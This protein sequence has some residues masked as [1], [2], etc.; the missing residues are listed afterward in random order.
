MVS[1]T[2]SWNK[3][4]FIV[5]IDPAAGVM[6]F[7]DTLQKLTGVPAARAK[8][9]PKTKGLWKGVLKNDF[10]LT[11]CK[12]LEGATCMLMGSAEFVVEPTVKTVFLEDLPPDE[13]AKTGMTAPAGFMNLGNT[14]YMNSTLQCI[15][16][17]P[18]LREGL[19]AYTQEGGGSSDVDGMFTNQL[20][21]TFEQVD[22][23]VD[24]IPPAGFV[25]A[26]RAAYPQFAQRGKSGGFS[27]QDAEE[28]FTSLFASVA[29]SLRSPGT[30]DA[31]FGQSGVAE[32]PEIRDSG[33]KGGVKIDNV[34]DA[35][36]GLKMEETLSC[37]EA[38]EAEPVVV[39]YDDTRKIV[40]NIQGG[41]GAAV[42]INHVAEGIKLGLEGE[43]EKNSDVLGR[44]ALWKK[45]SRIDRLP[46][47]F[48]CQ[49]MRFFWKAT[50]E[51]ADHQGVKCK[52]MRPVTFNE[53]IDMFEFCSARLQAI[54]KV[55]RDKAIAEEDARI[56]AR[57]KEQEAASNEEKK[58]GGADEPPPP[59][60]K[61]DA[62]EEDDD[63]E[64]AS[65]LAAALE[66]S[67][68]ESAPSAGLGLPAD[69]QGKY[70]LYGVVTHKGRD[71]DGG[72]YI[73]FVRMKGENWMCFDDDDVTPCKTTDILA[74]K[75]GG[76]HDMAYLTFYR[77]LE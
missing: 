62:M 37:P 41:H 38:G 45:T 21:R 32:L 29:K 1:V 65:A 64:E 53:T 50:P 75:G 48:M 76:D 72:H 36:F 51:S 42:Q 12:K 33:S 43:L 27:Q 24:S 54:L 16:H 40:C 61:D 74:L 10:D 7:K 23:A 31:A 73:S 66:M 69:F 44:N 6:A 35:L 57:A 68:S 71:S 56:L 3:Q 8:I 18:G 46:K 52:M 34:V 20:A 19:K 5:P 14:C 39:K 47:F 15:R 49:F 26:M 67:K 55:G 77:A 58:A 60:P 9:M 4:T 70:E 2:V 28:F 30:L 22:S 11:T 25:Q 13:A 63:D 59:A 17:T